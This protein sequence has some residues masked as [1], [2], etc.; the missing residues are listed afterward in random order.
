VEEANRVYRHV[1]TGYS[2]YSSTNYEAST[3]CHP[4]LE[5]S[6]EQKSPSQLTYKHWPCTIVPIVPLR[7]CT[8]HKSCLRSPH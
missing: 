3:K 4:L 6:G 2:C 7:T 8:F 1:I 5:R